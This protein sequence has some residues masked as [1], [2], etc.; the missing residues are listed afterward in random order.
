MG[1]YTMAKLAALVY[2]GCRLTELSEFIGVFNNP[3]H[4]FSIIDISQNPKG[5]I[6]TEDGF[7]LEIAETLET[8]ADQ[9]YDCIAITGGDVKSVIHNS[10]TDEFIRRHDSQGK[11]IGG[12][13]NGVWVVATSGILKGKKTTHT[14]HKSCKAPDEIIQTAEPYFEGAEY[15][16]ENV[17]I[18]GN[19]ISSKPWGK[20]Q[21]TVELAKLAGLVPEQGINQFKDYLS[22]NFIFPTE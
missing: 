2:D 8:K 19:I 21:F 7:V 1:E 20:I 6:T 22:G 9:I 17:V 14:A 11:V 10:V 12:I 18:D 13:C 3:Q 16:E 5:K 15:S 4:D